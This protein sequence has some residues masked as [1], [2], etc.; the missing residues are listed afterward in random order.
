MSTLTIRRVRRAD[1][2]YRCARCGYEATYP[3]A[4][5]TEAR[6]WFTKHSCAKQEQALLAAH[7]A[8][9]REKSI[10]RTPKPCRHKKAN[11]Q[12]GTNA[13]YVLDRC[14]CHPCA[15]A[16][17]KTDDERRRLQAYGRYQRYVDAHP[18]RLHVQALRD[19]GMG[20]KTIAVRSG[21]AHGTLWKLCY[22]KKVTHPDGTVT[23]TPSR[24]VLRETAE[25]LYAL[26]PTWSGQPLQ[27][28]D[29]AILT[30]EESTR[31]RRRL[32]ALVALGWSMTE[33]GRRLGIKHPGNAILIIKS[34]R[35]LTAATARR[36]AEIFDELCMTLP[37]EDTR[38]RRIA[39]IRSRNFA[40]AH[41][42]IPPLALEDLTT[43]EAEELQELDDVAI[44]RRLSG[45]RTV[46][47]TKSETVEAVRR[48]VKT[49][50]SQA[51]LE[52]FTG[53]NAH[54]YLRTDEA[55]A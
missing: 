13:C 6:Y 40:K 18:L 24:R 48:W 1:R 15:R 55:V 47:L 33:L 7:R 2:H 29:G 26:D 12:H 41:G 21:V 46:R 44:E 11:H 28:A 38:P 51:E 19:A 43:L 30:T 54:R 23:Q 35:R 3:N 5:A 36:A 14:R 9:Q 4:G 49:G 8:E 22:G 42:W 34:D 45:D 20:L 32:Q 16:R 27:L 52:R 53:I 50:R 17:A 37:R 39:A 31:I 10:D 25:K